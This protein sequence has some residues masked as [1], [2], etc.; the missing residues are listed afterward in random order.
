MAVSTKDSGRKELSGFLSLLSD[1]VWLLC[2]ATPY[3]LMGDA[4]ATSVKHE[5]TLETSHVAGSLFFQD[6]KP[7]SFPGMWTQG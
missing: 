5:G 4:R 1:G 6:T 7:T 2:T 3:F